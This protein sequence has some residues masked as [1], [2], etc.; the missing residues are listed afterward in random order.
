MQYVDLPESKRPLKNDFC[1]LSL[2]TQLKLLTSPWGEKYGGC[3][4]WSHT[5]VTSTFL[6]KNKI[7]SVNLLYI[8]NKTIKTDLIPPPLLKIIPNYVL[9]LIAQHPYINVF[10]FSGHLQIHVCYRGR[11]KNHRIHSRIYIMQFCYLINILN[12]ILRR[13]NDNIK[14]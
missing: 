6:S 10:L 5:S 9:P 14:T 12:R 3:P 8:L 13:R 2:L 1:L 4:D 11:H 7:Y